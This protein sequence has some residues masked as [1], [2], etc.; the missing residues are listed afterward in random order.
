MTCSLNGRII[1]SYADGTALFSCAQDMP[2]VI[3]EI[4]RITKK[5]FDWYNNN[6]MKA[7]PGKC[8]AMLSSN[9]QGQI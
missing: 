4:Q 5:I 1:T 8:H 3:F 9:T 7:N 6:H 2:S